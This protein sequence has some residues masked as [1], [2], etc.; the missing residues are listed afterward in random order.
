MRRL[1]GAGVLK[2]RCIGRAR[3]GI[4]RFDRC[5]GRNARCAG[6]RQVY[7]GLDKQKRS[8]EGLYPTE[9]AM[10]TPDGNLA[11]RKRHRAFLRAASGGPDASGI[12][13]IARCN[14]KKSADASGI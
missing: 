14:F 10:K 5:I 3:D 6:H 11:P 2:I 1:A 9:R 4:G 13:K 12:A 7:S 8:A